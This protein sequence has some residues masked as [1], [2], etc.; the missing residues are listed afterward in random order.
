MIRN[1]E[2]NQKQQHFLVPLDYQVF[3]AG[4]KKNDFSNEF[5]STIVKLSIEIFI[6]EITLAVTEKCEFEYR[7]KSKGTALFKLG[8]MK[9]LMQGRKSSFSI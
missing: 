9:I 1:I 2:I 5:T 7:N 6:E 8:N 3:E 4:I